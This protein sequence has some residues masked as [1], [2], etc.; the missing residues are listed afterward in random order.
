MLRRM[1]RSQD[2][3]L[4]ESPLTSSR[5][6]RMALIKASND[7]IGLV[8]TVS[9]VAEEV[10]P[11]DDMLRGLE[12]DLMLV[13]LLVA[14]RSVG[15]VALDTQMRAAVLEMQTLGGLIA[16]PADDR[17]ATLTDKLLCDKL[18]GAFLVAFPQAVVGT[19][20]ERWTDGVVLGDQIR[21]ARAAG[22][23]LE[24]QEY[25]IVRMTV[26]LAVAERQ[27]QLV[28]ALPLV[29]HDP[30]PV[31]PEP[32]AVDWQ[33]AFEHVVL[34]ASA[35]LQAQLHRFS[36]SLARAG[37]LKI[38]DVVAL[39]GCNVHSVRLLDPDGK[40]VAQAKLG[41]MGGYRAVRLQPPP[42]PELS[43]LPAHP[44]SLGITS[45]QRPDFPAEDGQ[46]AIHHVAAGLSEPEAG[47]QDEILADDPL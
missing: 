34:D 9:S 31:A 22:L 40:Q 28:M 7:S 26:D 18:L 38:G 42:A 35:S 41:Q 37:S 27:G 1:T 47:Q 10:V 21:N 15:F 32:E 20:L 45:D 19:P 44:R 33:P 46:L 36:M 4:A 2:K 17:A 5:A 8:V 6:V 13:T 29:D 25:R 24:D 12:D 3:D 39:P 43:E 16:Q 14:G 30:V 23:I 11:L